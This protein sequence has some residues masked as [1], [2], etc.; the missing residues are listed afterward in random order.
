MKK[1]LLLLFAGL[2][3]NPVTAQIPDDTNGWLYRLCKTWGYVKYYSQQKCG[4]P[5]D[6]LLNTSIG[7]VLAANSNAEYNDALLKMLNRAG[8]NAVVQNPPA[9][10]DTNLLV[11]T[12]WISDP[13]FS[14]E[15]KNFLNTFKSRIYPDTSKCFVRYNDRTN[16]DY[17][18]Y[19]DFTG[20]PFTLIYDYDRESHRLA[21]MFYYW[22][23]I[24]Y[25]FP[26]RSL[27]DQPW[28]KTLEQFIPMVRKA[29]GDLA[30]QKTM[31]KL[32]AR[33]NDSHGFYYSDTM[34]NLFWKGFYLPPVYFVRIGDKC[35]VRKVAEIQGIESGD[36]L[37]A[38]DG[39]PIR[40]IEDSLTQLTAASTPASLY[41]NIYY[42]M[43]LGS[44]LSD[45]ELTLTN[46]Q[47][48]AYT[49]KT[50]RIMTSD[51]WMNWVR[52]TDI[53]GSFVITT[54]GYGY[55]DMAK[56]KVA[57]VAAMYES[58]KTAPAII[59]D[60][61][62]Y[63]NSTLWALVPYFFA[64]P[65]ATAI[66]WYPALYDSQGYYY[67]PGWY[68]ILSNQDHF[69]NWSNPGAYPGK[70]Y[71]LVNQETQSQAE[72]TCQTLSYHPNARVIGSQT[73]GAD[74]NISYLNLPGGITTYFTSLG[75]YYADGYQQQRNGVRIDTLVYPTI[76]GIRAGQDEVL[77]AALDCLSET[78]II[79]ASE[80]S[81]SVYPN[82]VTSGALEVSLKLGK[83][84]E[85]QLSL[86]DIT[87]K[88]LRQTRYMCPD[89]NQTL[90][91][92]LSGLSPGVYFLKATTGSETAYKKIMVSR[93]D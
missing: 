55:V 28:D 59:F 45:V 36:I 66:F 53:D 74:G 65:I 57:E 81:F 87:G 64:G 47:S 41:R 32:V 84:C 30:F 27:M 23:V 56:L 54:C 12:G 58:L 1:I 46:S 16:P 52:E 61:R 14:Q 20:D 70:V 67:I 21:V 78:D 93:E 71:I 19:I 63:P 38:L 15:V 13:V 17:T 5:W 4:L 42:E 82:P 62:N 22:N 80:F 92:D 9:K 49:I 11:D 51:I 50:S 90:R 40:E 31:V 35:V 75:T 48:Q 68:Y 83:G 25:F 34:T 33:I 77:R 69:G 43:I 3:L 10:P 39:I 73:S 18:S 79:P 44:R 37:I 2:V 76:E 6:D 26:Y 29:S 89:G 86:T 60:L 88:V 24:N 72:Y 8:N 85:L 91:L 7:E